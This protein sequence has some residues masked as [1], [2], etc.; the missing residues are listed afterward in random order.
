M[1]GGLEEDPAVGLDMPDHRQVA[2]A[3]E[4]KRAVDDHQPAIRG[5]FLGQD[6]LLLA[7]P[8]LEFIER[9]VGLVIGD[10]R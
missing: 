8:R 9:R 2:A 10:R 1:C 6:A 4:M 3:H 7:H 5:K